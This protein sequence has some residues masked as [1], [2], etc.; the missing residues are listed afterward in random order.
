MFLLIYIGALKPSVHEDVAFTA[1]VSLQLLPAR[2]VSNSS[3][4]HTAAFMAS[5][6]RNVES[7]LWEAAHV[8]AHWVAGLVLC[9]VQCKQLKL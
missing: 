4:C 9:A 2:G 5:Q 6:E 8:G 1:E 7:E 3:P